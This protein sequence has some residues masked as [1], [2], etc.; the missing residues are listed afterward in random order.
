DTARLF[1]MFASPPENTL[2]WSDQGVEGA[3][4]FLQRLWRF[5]YNWREELLRY[6]EQRDVSAF[7]NLDIDLPQAEVRRR[8]HT[9]LKQAAYDYERMQFNTVVSAC[10]KILNELESDDARVAQRRT[11][12]VGSVTEERE[13]QVADEG[14]A[15]RAAV[16]YEG[17]GILLRLL[18]PITPHV[19]SAL[20]QE[21]GFKGD[22]IDAKWPEV[23]AKAPAQEEI[24]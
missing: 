19:A 15:I 9:V 7:S 14:K 8:I 24:D 13:R 21:L 20:W 11:P 12:M 23:D 2:E 1:M 10:M 17:L 5:A 4:R 16:M 3:Y 22:I 6:P 18:S